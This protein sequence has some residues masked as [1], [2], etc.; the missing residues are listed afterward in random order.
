[1]SDKVTHRILSKMREVVQA[2]ASCRVQNHETLYVCRLVIAS[3]ALF[4]RHIPLHAR[5]QPQRA[6]CLDQH[7]DPSQRGNTLVL[8]SFVVF[9]T[10][11]L[12]RRRGAVGS[13]RPHSKCTHHPS[14][15]NSNHSVAAAHLTSTPTRHPLPTDH[16][17]HTSSQAKPPAP[18]T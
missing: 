16:G 9:K 11:A 7:W 10:Q 12:L 4:D 8:V 13:H 2:L 1:M 5:R 18:P 14:G 17:T 6:E 15:D 3:F